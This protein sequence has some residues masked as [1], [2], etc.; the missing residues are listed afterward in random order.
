MLWKSNIKEIFN[1]LKKIEVKLIF[2]LVWSF[3]SLKL[4]RNQ[5]KKSADFSHTLSLSSGFLLLAFSP[6]P[7]WYIFHPGS[8]SYYCGHLFSCDALMAGS[9]LGSAPIPVLSL[10]MFLRIVI[11]LKFVHYWPPFLH[12]HYLIHFLLLFI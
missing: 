3:S 9:V 6:F 4:P 7:C 12:S 2:G 1:S 11:N 5:L 8:S 10:P